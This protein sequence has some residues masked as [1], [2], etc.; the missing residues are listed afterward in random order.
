MSGQGFAQKCRLF[1]EGREVPFISATLMCTAGEP[2]SAMIDL[3]PADP[4]KFIHPRTKVD[5]FVQ[6]RFNFGDDS[7][8]LAF[9]GEVV[10]RQ[11]GKSQD[12]RYFRITATDHLSYLED[13]KT[14]FYNHNFLMNHFSDVAQGSPN[15]PQEIKSVGASSTTGAATVSSEMIR[16]LLSPGNKD[17]VDGVSAVFRSLKNIN[18]LYK[19]AWERLRIED[20]LRIFSSG[21][22]VEFLAE[23]QKE[24]FLRSFLGSQGGLASLREILV[25]VL[26]LVFH[27]LVSL[28]FPALVKS[29]KDKDSLTLGNFLFVPDG[30]SLPPP[31]CNVIFPNRLKSFEF[32]EDFR[33]APTR[34]AFKASHP[35]F[36]GQ[37]IQRVTYPVQYYPTSFS[38][39][40]KGRAGSSAAKI[41][42]DEKTS[43]LGPSALLKDPATGKTYDTLRYGDGK[44]KAP[45]KVSVSLKLREADFLTNEESI[46]GIFLATE[47]MIPALTSLAAKVSDEKRFSFTQKVGEYLFFKK[48]FGARNASAELMFHPFMVPGF[49]CLIV[50]DSDT[51]QS[52]IAKVQSVTHTLSNQGCS[53]SITLGYARTFDEVD[54]LTGG[55]GDPP[56][57]PWFDKTRFGAPNPDAFKAETT[58]LSSVEKALTT[59]E[60]TA[61]SRLKTSVCFTG[62]SSF[63]QYLVGVDAVTDV[64]SEKNSGSQESSKLCT[65]RGAATYLTNKFR[66]ISGTAASDEFSREYV[67]RPIP[68]LSQSFQFQGATTGATL[69]GQPIVPDEFAFFKAESQGTD[70]GR[71]DGIGRADESVLKLRRGIIDEYVANLRQQRGFRG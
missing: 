22:L 68:T 48:R 27:Q 13:A 40:M 56:V 6:D 12:A 39:Y 54:A 20:R 18:L 34:F 62:L 21:R 46:R 57:P 58:Y 4:I 28:P 36:V 42:D 66:K 70:A 47:T 31:K 41:T 71:F 5:L 16:I 29:S 65:T 32:A 8:Y 43:A 69:H 30:Y 44:D 55:V 38:D 60:V 37:N 61:R 64:D 24:E 51:N 53:T 63:Y 25:S 3:V 2:I 67:R 9:E 52:L 7:Y 23:I 49:N 26:G 35:E 45:G 1:L 17:L 10:S 33:S 50:D 14:Y 59:E 11:M 15:L 19:S